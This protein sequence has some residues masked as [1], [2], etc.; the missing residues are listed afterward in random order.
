MRG[1]SICALL[2]ALACL[3]GI[4]AAGQPL[5]GA[6]NCEIFPEDN[7]WN[8]RVD[9]LP[10]HPRSR[11]IIRTIGRDESVHPDFGSGK[12]DG[13]PI[14]IPFTTVPGD[15]EKVPVKFFYADESDPGPYPIPP[16]APIEG[17]PNG[18]GDRHVLVVDRAACK[19][20]EMFNARPVNGGERWRAG[21]GAVW[22]LGSNKL[23]PRGWT[24]A[25]A[26]GLPILPG[27]ARWDEVDDGVIDHALRFTVERTRRAFIY[28]ARHFASN[29]TAKRFPA[30]G[31]RLRL[32]R[33]FDISGFPY[34]ARVVLKAM[35][36]YGIILADNGSDMYVSGAP[37]PNWNNDALHSLHRVKARHFVV[38]DTSKL[39]KP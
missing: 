15:Q 6:P 31:Q 18:D 13:G 10:L 21:S 17:G 38:V 8:L 19:L 14:G 35:K 22:N 16:N 5:P 28:P 26:A 7:H 34:Q 4:P 2:L 33:G 11:R 32:K 27:L 12:W 20:Y 30:M 36:I 24:S 37:N 29:L 23:R 3:G 9:K 39:P 25:D 1:A